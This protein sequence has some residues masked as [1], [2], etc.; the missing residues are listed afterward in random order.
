MDSLL[1]PKN[2]E[3]L[4]RVFCD[5]AKIVYQRQKRLNK[6]QLKMKEVSSALVLAE[7]LHSQAF[8]FE[9]VGVLAENFGE[10]SEDQALKY[11]EE[12]VMGDVK[13][14]HGRTIKIDEDGMKSLYKEPV[15]GKHIVASENYEEGRAKRLPWIRHALQNSEA[16]YVSEETVQGT[17]RRTYLYTATVS[18]PLVPKAQVS[19]YVV[20]V[21]EAKNEALRLVTAYSMFKRNK[22]LSIVEPCYRYAKT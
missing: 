13:D 5:A 18:I 10:I 22:F 2:A 20:V 11:Y 19:Y 1:S 17:F 6:T 21:R 9:A 12:K 16:I 14:V 8:R 15:S 3:R 7:T 4:N